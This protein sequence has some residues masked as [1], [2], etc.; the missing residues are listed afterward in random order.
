MIE[1]YFKLKV[2]G[3][4]VLLGVL[5]AFVFLFIVAWISESISLFRKKR[6]LRKN[7]YKY[8]PYGKSMGEWTLDNNTLC[9][10]GHKSVLNMKYRDLKE[11]IRG[12]KKR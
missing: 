1:T 5:A 8:N 11:R 3:F 10:I 9:A 2:F 12:E 6:L 4:Y 7:G